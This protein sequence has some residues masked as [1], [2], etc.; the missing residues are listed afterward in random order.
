MK[1]FFGFGD[2]TRPAEGFLSWQHITFVT[3]LLVIMMA[4]AIIFGHINRN[5][6][7]K[8]KNKVLIVSAILIDSVEIF[9]IIIFYLRAEGDFDVGNVLPLFLCSLQ[10]VTIPLAAF[11]KG[12]LKEAALDFVFIFGLLGAVLGTYG[13]GQNYDCYPVLSIDNVASGITH[14]I[15]GFASLYIAISG[16]ASMKRKNIHITF[17]IIGVFSIVAYTCGALLDKN[18][19]FL[20][21]GDGTPYDI[22]FNLVKGHPIAY[23][24]IVIALFVVYIAVF[25]TVYF[26]ATSKKRRH[27]TSMIPIK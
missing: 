11:S 14:C 24:I 20:F 4:L 19:M 16:M 5:K 9:K 15:S 26:F 7:E 3:T 8:I 1:E 18:Y 12:R 6:D 27:V 17:S 2:Y 21:R 23:P 22:F 10:L 13:A 25:Y